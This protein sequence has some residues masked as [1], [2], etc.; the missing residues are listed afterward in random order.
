MYGKP[1]QKEKTY[2]KS[3]VRKN[4]MV[5]VLTGKDR[6]KEG[7]VLRV[8]PSKGAA[9]VERVNHAKKHT[10]ANPQK[11]Q[12]GGILEREAPIKLSNLQ[13]LCPSCGERTRVGAKVTDEGTAR[14]C[15]KC[16]AELNK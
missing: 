12:Q 4:D 13:V 15:R 9:I 10:R 6:G 7:K 1:K 11:N 3:H 5:V 14:S 16:Q 2:G 8:I